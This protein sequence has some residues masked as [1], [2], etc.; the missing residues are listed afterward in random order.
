MLRQKSWC[1]TTY[2]FH[3]LA[4]HKFLHCV[5]SAICLLWYYWLAVPEVNASQSYHGPNVSECWCTMGGM[6]FY[7]SGKKQHNIALWFASTK[8]CISDEYKIHHYLMFLTN[9]HLSYRTRAFVW[10]D[11]H[12]HNKHLHHCTQELY[13]YFESFA[14]RRIGGWTNRHEINNFARAHKWI[15]VLC[16]EFIIFT[17]RLMVFLL[18]WLVR[19]TLNRSPTI[20]AMSYLFI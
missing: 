15:H 12:P 2:W 16:V 14:D 10:T 13:I 3:P 11:G 4:S 8:E 19:Q 6:F 20:N 9:R 17:C 1:V 7:H 18:K 5:A